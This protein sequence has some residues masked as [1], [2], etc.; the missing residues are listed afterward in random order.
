MVHFEGWAR[1][2]ANRRCWR[3]HLKRQRNLSL[4]FLKPFLFKN[5][6]LSSFSLTPVEIQCIWERRWKENEVLSCMWLSSHTFLF[7]EDLFNFT[8]L[9]LI[10]KLLI[11]RCF[12]IKIFCINLFKKSVIID[13]LIDLL[14]IDKSKTYS[15]YL[16]GNIL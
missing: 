5:L 7:Y 15:A 6:Q 3:S 11:S 1:I 9:V 14:L 12:N 8:I 10:Q 4:N 16:I 2:C 13:E